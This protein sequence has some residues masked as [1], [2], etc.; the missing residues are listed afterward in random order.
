MKI[1]E[2]LS[3]ANKLLKNSGIDSY[4]LDS[5]LILS[6]VL[7]MD[8][9]SIFMNKEKEIDEDKCKYFFQL[10]SM[11]VKKMPV[12]YIT[13]QSEFMGIDF[14]IE[15]GVLIPRPDTEILVETVLNDIR[16][17]NY[18]TLCDVCCGSGVI[19]L[20]IAKLADS[21]DVDCSDISD[22]AYKVTSINAEKLKLEKKVKVYK[23]NLM[24]F[25]FDKNKKYDVIVS[26]PPYIKS[27]VIPT[28]M[29][30]VKDYE[31]YIAL[32]GGTDGLDFYRKITE[33]GKV[34]LNPGGLLAFEIGY[35]QNEQVENIMKSNGFHHI[36]ILKD[37][38][39]NY[40][41]VK[42]IK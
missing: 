38:G 35:D 33:Q 40:R 12:K 5:Q 13:K 30:D 39:D 28:L 32:C 19:G 20:S 27:S 18:R 9:L 4:I 24:E 25:A 17:K 42:G 36:V 6:F 10:I 21:I 16:E 14:Y 1:K 7:N 22:T 11:R 31:P 34:L 15:P 37:L 29:E 41:V 2:M 3:E 23:S 26:N 8:K